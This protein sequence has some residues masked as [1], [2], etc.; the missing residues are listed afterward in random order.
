VSK[1]S[2]YAQ[3][4]QNSSSHRGFPVVD[5]AT[6]P[7]GSW[8]EEGRH[9][10]GSSPVGSARLNSSAGPA[11]DPVN[12]TAAGKITGTLDLAKIAGG[13][14]PST[15]ADGLDTGIDCGRAVGVP[16][17]PEFAA[18]FTSQAGT[19]SYQG[20]FT[21][22]LPAEG[23]SRG[24]LTGQADVALSGRLTGELGVRQ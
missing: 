3:H 9:L 18:T 14:L 21:G 15:A 22:T 12:A 6:G 13:T 7:A 4:L 24:S 17:G 1:L 16:L 11:A 10:R 23:D 20:E 8:S 5:P 19:L 2:G